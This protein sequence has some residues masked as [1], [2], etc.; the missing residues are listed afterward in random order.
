MVIRAHFD[1]QLNALSDAILLLASKVGEEMRAALSALRTLDTNKALEVMEQDKLINKERFE[2]EEKCYELIA[3]Q[4]PTARDLRLIISAINIV[5]D[6]E[7]MG[8]QAKG[9]A[10][11]T[12]R[13]ATHP[14]VDRPSELQQMGDLVL[15]MLKQ[16][17]RAYTLR[18]VSLA[19]TIAKRDEDVDALYA[20]VYTT[21]MTQMALAG[22]KEKAEAAYEVLRAAREVERFGDLVTNI[23]ERIVFL[24]TGEFGEREVT[25]PDVT[26]AL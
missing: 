3:M 14:V 23:A 20:V 6:L 21:S 17:M 15:E 18:D 4:Q 26:K 5:T 16:A 22:V 11:V 13:L 19:K 1:Q 24:V 9:V 8:D 10:R 25:A 7:H 2:I 12:A